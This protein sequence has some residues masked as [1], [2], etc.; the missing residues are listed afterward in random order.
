MATLQRIK[1]Y[2]DKLYIISRS[3]GCSDYIKI[4]QTHQFV[5]TIEECEKLI[6]MAKKLEVKVEIINNTAFNF[7]A[8]DTRF[9]NFFFKLCRYVRSK[10]FIIVLDNAIMLIKNYNIKPFNSIYIAHLM[11]PMGLSM[12][13]I[14]NMHYLYT[15]MFLPRSK[16]SFLKKIEYNNNYNIHEI[17]KTFNKAGFTLIRDLDIRNQINNAIKNKDYKLVQRLMYEPK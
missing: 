6:F 4:G 9:Q 12:S 1:P 15:Y 3:Q 8:I 13:L 14:P 11:H 7:S 2:L 17:F 16:K 5:G 10:N